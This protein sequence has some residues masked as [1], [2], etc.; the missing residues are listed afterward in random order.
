MSQLEKLT[1]RWL[2]FSLGLRATKEAESVIQGWVQEMWGY[3]IAAASHGI[4]HSVHKD[5]QAAGG[6]VLSHACTAACGPR[7]IPAPAAGR[8]RRAL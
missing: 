5:F 3:A 7:L 8:V 4:V 1:P 6:P 2:E